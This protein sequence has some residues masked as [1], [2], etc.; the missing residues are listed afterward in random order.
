MSIA[1]NI[2]RFRGCR[3]AWKLAAAA[4]VPSSTWYAIE[5]GRQGNVTTDTL[6]KIAAALGCTVADLV[7]EPSTQ[8]L[9]P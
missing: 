7:S 4:G 8:E 9:Q 6:G 1:T 5:S 3:V 2:K